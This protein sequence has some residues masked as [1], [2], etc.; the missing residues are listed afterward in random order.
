[1]VGRVSQRSKVCLKHGFSH[2]HWKDSESEGQEKQG[3]TRK[4]P[5]MLSGIFDTETGDWQKFTRKPLKTSRLL[6]TFPFV[7]NCYWKAVA[8]PSLQDSGVI[9]ELKSFFL[10]VCIANR[11]VDCWAQFW[12]PLQYCWEAIPFISWIESGS[13]LR[14]MSVHSHKSSWME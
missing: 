5:V 1:M 3:T 7:H 12:L 4:P 13:D 14:P 9:L 10:F 8:F 11:W 6:A 2:S